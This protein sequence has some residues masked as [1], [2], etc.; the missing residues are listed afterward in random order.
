MWSTTSLRKRSPEC[1]GVRPQLLPHN[2]EEFLTTRRN[3]SS[4]RLPPGECR[5]GL[6]RIV[7]VDNGST[8][9]SRQ[10]PVLAGL[11]GY[12]RWVHDKARLEPVS[13]QG[14]AGRGRVAGFLRSQGS[15]PVGSTATASPRTRFRRNGAIAL[16][17]RQS[18]GRRCRS[19]AGRLPSGPDP[20]PGTGWEK[21]IGSIRFAGLQ[22]GNPGGQ[23][24][25]Q[26]GIQFDRFS[27]VYQRLFRPAQVFGGDL[28][29]PPMHARLFVVQQQ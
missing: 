25:F 17:G 7:S 12:L 16:T 23:S 3:S 9:R 5:P 27:Q 6:R 4:G 15:G 20:G 22:C 19:P 2:E 28:P 11:W 18:P 13:F 14:D 10:F 29:Q 21:R 1:T 26:S 24:G 8:D